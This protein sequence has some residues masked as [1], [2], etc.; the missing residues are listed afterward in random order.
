[1]RREFWLMMLAVLTVAIG[2][3]QPQFSSGQDISYP[4]VRKG[5]HFLAAGPLTV[6]LTRHTALSNKTTKVEVNLLLLTQERIVYQENEKSG[7]FRPIVN[8][9]AGRND[10]ILSIKILDSMKSIT[11]TLDKNKKLF[12]GDVLKPSELKITSGPFSKD[13]ESKYLLFLYLQ[14]QASLDNTLKANNERRIKI[15]LEK[16]DRFAE[17]I[18]QND[19]NSYVGSLFQALRSHH[20]ELNVIAR[21][22]ALA[23]KKL[24]EASKKYAEDAM[25]SDALAKARIQMAR[26][27]VLAGVLADDPLLITDSYGGMIQA[28]SDNIF[29]RTRFE[30]ARKYAEGAILDE[31][32]G[33]AKRRSEAFSARDNLV[34]Q[35]EKKLSLPERAST[36]EF[37]RELE[38]DNDRTSAVRSLAN[39]AALYRKVTPRGNP[40]LQEEVYYME[41]LVPYA[42]T[43]KQMA[44]EK[45]FELANKTL[46][47]ARNIPPGKI[48]D[49]DRATML[50]RAAEFS[51][52]AAV[53]E[54][55][56]ERTLSGAYNPKAIFAVRLLEATKKYDLIDVGADARELEM[57]ALALCGMG[58]AALD[59]GVKIA[60]TRVNST[61]VHLYLA[62]LYAA[63]TA[64]KKTTI[65]AAREAL[66]KALKAGYSDFPAVHKNADLKKIIDARFVHDYL[67]PIIQF[68]AG[69]PKKGVGGKAEIQ[70]T[71]TSAVA[72]K[73]VEVILFV[74]SGKMMKPSGSF[75][76]DSLGPNQTKVWQ[77]SSVYASMLIQNEWTIVSYRK[78]IRLEKAN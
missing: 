25:A 15:V 6:V 55:G 57:V 50:W 39:L 78:D 1:M 77:N 48:H 46:D 13:E 7:A 5:E 9:T 34:R 61:M 38:K 40:W 41:S 52:R 56:Q 21:D 67:T 72:I 2:V 53:L 59:L 66:T 8:E 44:I 70:F 75:K 42:A 49:L 18:K 60:E 54:F 22:Q 73:D 74:K 26:A 12:A 27:G 11:W 51:V 24:Q 45:L 19:L 4:G 64:D 36:Q 30:I 76:I 23:F 29:E 69:A 32:N 47:E 28:A 3:G 37:A 65:P 14:M 33:I 62:K 31:L 68:K 16:A 71:N 35:V 10:P 20:D 17:H 63:S 43:Q 58:D